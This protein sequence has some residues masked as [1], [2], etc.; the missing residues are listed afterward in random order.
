M[1]R[2]I[3]LFIT[4]FGI[5]FLGSLPLGTLNVTVSELVVTNRTAG[6]IRFGV[7]A[8]AVEITLVRIALAAVEWLTGLRRYFNLFRL[9]AILALLAVSG[10]SLR[11][12]WNRDMFQASAIPLTSLHPFAAGLLLS[13]L[14]PLHLPFWMG[15]SAILRS[16][17]LLGS[18]PVEYNLFI[19]G[20]GLGTALA[21]IGY[22]WAG[23]YLQGHLRG[24][25][26]L[27]DALVGF[28]LLGTA[29]V[30]GYKLLSAYKPSAASSG[31]HGDRL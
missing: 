15:W 23:E 28:T 3:R 14:N 17:G 6:A 27:I 24:D 10:F 9:M 5:S 19:T 30:Q 12:A 8:I 21:F 25:Q 20:I 4:A 26:P 18:N 7:A 1:N 22:G 31:P 16:K 2:L 29:L 11:A 13:A